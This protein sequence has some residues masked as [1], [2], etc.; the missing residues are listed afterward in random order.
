MLNHARRRLEMTNKTE[1]VALSSDLTYLDGALPND[2]IHVWHADFA[3]VQGTNA[4]CRLLEREEQDR[5]SRFRVG[6]S[7]DQFVI[8]RA[9]LRLVLAGYLRI[10]PRDVRFQTREHGKPELKGKRELEFNLSHTDGAAALAIT[11]ARA[12]GIDVERVRH[13]VQTL[14]IADRFFSRTESDWLHSQPASKLAHSFFACWTAKEAYI[15]ARGI[16]LSM[17][18]HAFTVIPSASCT[19]PEVKLC[20]E[21]A[22]GSNFRIRS[23]EL[24]P[25]LAGAVAVDGEGLRVRLSKWVWP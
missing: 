3:E 22:R 17:P 1:C 16:G 19:I 24:G 2:E 25:D 13:D 14:D 15:K 9:F 8:S 6:A 18:L 21:P 12:I 10:D 20:I 5:A 23:L 7:R 4:L 11:R